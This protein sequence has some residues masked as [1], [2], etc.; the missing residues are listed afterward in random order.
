MKTIFYSVVFSILMLTIVSCIKEFQEP[1]DPKT[2]EINSETLKNTSNDDLY[3]ILGEERQIAYSV[4]NMQ[5]AVDFINMNLSNSPF[6]GRRIFATHLYLQFLPNTEEHLTILNQLS[7]AGEIVLSNYPLHCKIVK[8]GSFIRENDP[9]KI[10]YAPL[11]TTV[12]L[13]YNIPNVPYNIIEWVYEPTADE[14]DLEVTA[15]VLT[16]NKDELDIMINGTPIAQANLLDYLKLP[17]SEKSGK[18]TPQG[19]FVVWDTELTN[20]NYVGVRNTHVLIGRLIWWHSISTNGNGEFVDNRTYRGTVHVRAAWETQDFTIRKHWNEVIGLGISDYLMELTKNNNNRTYETLHTDNHKWY[21]ATV[22]NALVKYNSNMNLQAVPGVSG[23]ANIWVQE[24]NHFRGAA[25][26]MKQYT[27]STTYNALLADWLVW[28]SPITFPIATVM[29]LLFGHLY[30]DMIVTMNDKNTKRIDQLVFHEAGHFSHAKKAGG[31]FWSVFVNRELENIINSGDP[32]RDGTQPSE[33]SGQLIA[34]CEG[35][36]T[37]TEYLNMRD[38]YGT[39][40]EG[41]N[42]HTHI[43][44][45]T[46]RSVPSTINV[47]DNGWFLTGLIWDIMDNQGET[48]PFSLFINSNVQPT[49]STS[50]IDN[51]SIWNLSSNLS[52]LYNNLTSS[53]NNANDLRTKLLNGYPNSSSQIYQLF[54]S[55]G[56]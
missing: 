43:E 4:E 6:M 50:I 46:M 40:W 12:P 35:W 13:G 44:N 51:L 15:L 56:Y 41:N 22:N 7:I 24:G 31:S 25:P 49:S 5:K 26:M 14:F 18:F 32:Y 28:L 37:F 17:E 53:T 21:K 36:A 10:K 11:Y 34:L 48:S 54:Q 9:D 39:D 33:W 55:Y 52:P 45:F 30:P 42:A 3:I 20:N 27:W 19:R 47:E 16:A 8:Q 29:N 1:N 38:Y 2:I 23:W